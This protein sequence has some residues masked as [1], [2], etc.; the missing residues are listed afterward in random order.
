VLALLLASLPLGCG[1]ARS[2]EVTAVDLMSRVKD[3]DR[4]PAGSPIAVEAQDFGGRPRASLRVPGESRLT[5]TIPIPRRA[6]LRFYAAVA[7]AAGAAVA[8]RVGISDDR[9]YQTLLEQAVTSE[10]TA[11]RGWVELAADLSHFAG[12]QLSLFF[13]PDT[14]RWHLVLGTHVV[15]GSPAGVYLG[16]PALVT[17]LDAARDY[18]KRRVPAAR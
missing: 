5:F 6:V 4:R 17:D 12:P 7:D 10:E 9:F 14:R 18:V 1:S 11:A 15:T 3:A 16:E 8:F 13:R 2:G